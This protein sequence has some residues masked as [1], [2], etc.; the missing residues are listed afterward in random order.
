[1]NISSDKTLTVMLQSAD[2]AAQPY[3]WIRTAAGPQ[4]GFGHLRRCMIL[5]QS[6][7]DCCRPLFLLDA[8]DRW[9]HEQLAEQGFEYCLARDGQVWIGI[10]D[11][12][13][14]LIDTRLADGLDRL[15]ATAQSRGVPII[16]IHDMGL[17]PLPSD[18]VIDGSIASS[19]FQGA[20]FQN[21]KSFC[22]TNYMV[23]DPAFQAL[24][25]KRMRICKNVRSVVVSLGGGDSRKYFPVILKG[26]K[27][28]AQEAVEVIGLKGFVN[29]GQ[30]TLEQMDWH[31]LHFRWEG[32]SPD[33]FLI[34]ADL[35]ITAGGLSAYEALCAG[36][37]LLSF[38]YDPLQQA[39]IN[40]IEAAGACI[41]LGPGDDLDSMRLAEVLSSISAGMHER[42]RISL[43][44]RKMIDGR[45]AERVSHIVRQLICER[46]AMNDQEIIE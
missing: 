4:I 46:Q 5:A 9:C 11:P 10:T 31:P 44:G 6:L 38:S 24:H 40:A 34:H 37:P 33:R 3:L 39:S 36:T 23:L 16:S 1:M 26:L 13:A 2:V 25:Q 12:A 41:N 7:L 27:A 32:G 8:Q 18:I 17:N 15:I 19:L 28:W 14:L 45:G 29:W 22:G 21:A 42:R 20:F 43:N 30:E 35:A